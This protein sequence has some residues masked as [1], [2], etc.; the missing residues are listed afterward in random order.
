MLS[1]HS[2]PHSE[3]PPFTSP[4]PYPSTFRVHYSLGTMLKP[5][6]EGASEGKGCGRQVIVVA[7]SSDIVLMVLD[8]SK[9]SAIFH[10][11]MQSFTLLLLLLVD[12]MVRWSLQ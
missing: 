3:S 2:P 10:I 1:R 9:V 11:L 8:A 12:K 5:I 4:P 7:K 6:I